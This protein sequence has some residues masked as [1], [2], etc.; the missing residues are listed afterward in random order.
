[1]S[2]LF[3][4]IVVAIFAA[5]AWFGY[6]KGFVR[7]VCGVLIFFISLVIAIN[8]SGLVTNYLNES[9]F[10]DKV[11]GQITES[12]ESVIGKSVESAKV[13]D[14]FKDKPSGFITLIERFGAN[15]D[16]LE[17]YYNANKSESEVSGVRLIASYIAA[18]VS[19]LISKVISFAILFFG[20][21]LILTIIKLIL[22]AIFKLPVLSS[23]NKTFGLAFG[24]IKGGLFAWIISIVL[25]HILNVLVMMYPQSVSPSL[26][27]NTVIIKYLGNINIFNILSYLI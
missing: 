5:C 9:V 15:V 11:T 27:E 8:F 6:K 10:M 22:E 18:P 7:T 14:L 21:M 19:D 23:V 13:D 3:D 2:L 4:L 20:S 25:V 17:S 24:I 12:I 26:I 1:M 16:E